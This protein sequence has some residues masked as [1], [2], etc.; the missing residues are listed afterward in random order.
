MLGGIFM[1]KKCQESGD[2]LL[3]VL[4]W[5]YHCP[6]SRTGIHLRDVCG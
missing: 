6:L 5:A 4:H 2:A 1:A 3:F